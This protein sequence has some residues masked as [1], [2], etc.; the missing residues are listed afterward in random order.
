MY[1]VYTSVAPELLGQVRPRLPYIITTAIER[2]KKER[3]ITI[4]RRLKWS[5]GHENKGLHIGQGDFVEIRVAHIV[6]LQVT[7]DRA[8]NFTRS[9]VPNTVKFIIKKSPPRR[10]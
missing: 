7:C 4:A 5:E 10:E 6:Y 2:S 1:L 9:P 3:V 8:K